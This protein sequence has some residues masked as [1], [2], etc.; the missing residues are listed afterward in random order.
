MSASAFAAGGRRAAAVFDCYGFKRYGV[1]LAPPIAQ[2]YVAVGVDIIL[3]FIRN[4]PIK[5]RAVRIRHNSGVT[6]L[7]PVFVSFV[8]T[9][10]VNRYAERSRIFLKLPS[11]LYFK[12]KVRGTSPSPISSESGITAFLSFSLPYFS[13][14]S[15]SIVF[16]P[17]TG[18]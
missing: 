6:T 4:K 5:R 11:R 7:I 17:S 18:I 10:I 12:F 13:V 9:G 16:V 14:L 1:L 3:D 8:R 15:G 2:H